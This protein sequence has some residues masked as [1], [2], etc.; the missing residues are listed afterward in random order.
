[1]VRRSLIVDGEEPR[2][3]AAFVGEAGS[4]IVIEACATDMHANTGCSAKA[5]FQGA[6]SPIA[7]TASAGGGGDAG[8]GGATATASGAL[9]KPCGYTGPLFTLLVA[10][11]RRR[12][13]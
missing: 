7:A 5:T 1:L 6:G 13:P 2:V 10:L 11:M 8:A 9:S 3:K 12:R 4:I